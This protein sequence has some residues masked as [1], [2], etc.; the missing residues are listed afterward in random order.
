ML[1]M[2]FGLPEEL[3]HRYILAFKVPFFLMISKR[4]VKLGT[5]VSYNYGREYEVKMTRIN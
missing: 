1:L 3:S 5:L 2:A 4:F